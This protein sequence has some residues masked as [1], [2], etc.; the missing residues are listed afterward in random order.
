MKSSMGRNIRELSFICEKLDE[1]LSS[2]K[3]NDLKDFSVEIDEMLSIIENAKN[4]AEEVIML[5]EEL[6]ENQDIMEIAQE[7][8]SIDLEE[9]YQQLVEIT[10]NV[11]RKLQ[12][13][14]KLVKNEC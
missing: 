2:N 1:I 14:R 5:F 12:R 7:L 4:K 6:R 13:I 9:Q 8:A 10:E 3:V 11:Y